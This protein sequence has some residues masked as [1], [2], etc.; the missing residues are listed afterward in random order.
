MVS[1]WF[2]Y[3]I[4]SFQEQRQTET[5]IAVQRDLPVLTAPLRP[6]PAKCRRRKPLAAQRT[7]ANAPYRPQPY[8][9]RPSDQAQG[10]KC[11]SS[12]VETNSLMI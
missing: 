2:I 7:G 6:E 8:R 1:V 5:L 12:P 10:S 9:R 3:V 11:D 4:D